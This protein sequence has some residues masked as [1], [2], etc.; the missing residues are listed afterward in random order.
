MKNTN[1]N[2]KIKI[3]NYHDAN[4]YIKDSPFIRRGYLLN[5]NT[6]PKVLKSLFMLHNE[7]INIWSHLIASILVICLIIYTILKINSIEIIKNYLFQ[8]NNISSK[9]T[10]FSQF[11]KLRNSIFSFSHNLENSISKQLIIPEYYYE[12]LNNLNTTLQTIIKATKIVKI[13]N[14]LENIS[15]HFKKLKNIFSI[16]NKSSLEKWPLYI[17]LISAFLC[18][19]FSTIFHMVGNMSQKIH[20]FFSRFDYGGISLLIS[21]STFP[22]YYYFFYCDNFFKIFYLLF[23]TIFGLSVFLYSFTP[24]FHLKETK[25]IRGTLFL[26]FGISA[27]IPILHMGFFG[28]NIKGFIEMPKLFFWYIGGISYIIG[29][30]LFMF[31][32]PEKLYPGKFDIIGSSHQIFHILVVIGVITHY[33]GSLDA[34]YYRINNI[35]PA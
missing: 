17:F 33:F 21:G 10:N 22:P 13:N 31:R 25:K 4:S 32:V 8:L 5:C 1:K 29:A 2:E 24:K 11:E 3:V 27:G 34:Y 12:K 28:N 18:L 16:H 7:T 30:F 35:C 26:I 23:I 19:I 15:S 9:I 20:R 14:L 6:I